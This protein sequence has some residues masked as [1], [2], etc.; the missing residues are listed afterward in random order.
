MRIAGK[1]A[2][3]ILT[4]ER[5]DVNRTRTECR[6]IHYRHDD[7]APGKASRIKRA[8]QFECGGDA[9]VLSRVDAGCHD[10]RRPFANSIDEPHGKPVRLALDQEFV[11]TVPLFPVWGRKS[12]D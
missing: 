1:H 12:S 8:P 2:I 7:Y 5:T 4:V 10:E 11:H 3:R 6:R 9:G